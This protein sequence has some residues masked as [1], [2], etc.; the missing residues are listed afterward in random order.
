MGIV[1][2]ARDVA[3]DRPVAIKLLP[4]ALAG[5]RRL[6]ERFVR[7]ARLAARLSHPNI[8]PIHAV[9]E[10]GRLVW[11]VMAF[12]PGES[13]GQRLRA[14]GPL[15][16]A[17]VARILRDIAW[18]LAYAHGQGVI[19]RDVKPD[20][21]LLE[22]GGRRALIA[23][24][25]IARPVQDLDADQEPVAGTI[26]YLSPEQARGERLDGRSDLYSLGVVGY[27][28]LAARLPYP[29]ATLAELVE[30]QLAG[31]P[32]ALATVGP[33]L[34]RA[35][36]RAIDRCL[37]LRPDARPRNG[38]ELA[39]VLERLDSMPTDLPAPLRVWLTKGNQ[40]RGALFLWTLTFGLPA[41]FTAFALLANGIHAGGAALLG[42]GLVVAAPWA[43]YFGSRLTQTRKVLAAG[44]T[45]S[46]LVLAIRNQAER[47]RE[48]IAFEIGKPPT[49]L[50]RVLRRMTWGL[51]GGAVASAFVL[52]WIGLTP[53]MFK[54]AWLTLSGLAVGGAILGMLIPGRDLPARDRRSEW[55][56]KF[57]AGPFGRGL[58]RL[59]GW[60]LKRR[61]SPEQSLHRPTELALGDAA[62][63]LFQALPETER[64][65]LQ[66]LP[67]QIRYLSGQAQA[68][69]RKIEELDDL[70]A[71]AAPETLFGEGRGR[72]SDGGAAELTEARE[73][74]AAR[75]RETI[76][77]LEALRLGLLRLHAGNAV[78]ESLTADLEAAEELKQRLEHLADGQ[79]AVQLVLKGE[80]PH[81]PS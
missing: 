42:L 21:V 12:V 78:P 31:P 19:H 68:M 66:Q 36:C 67:Q 10:A 57:W 80:V 7:E 41:G 32:P 14:R 75:L 27:T 1:F 28:A 29:A 79:A 65:D 44:Y 20:N 46:D 61:E 71:R 8:V 18:G 54:Y 4:P 60:R 55:R 81:H 34:P 30:R 37:S 2:L 25:G 70:I 33:H 26:G 74:W 52:P 24:F 63:A 76:S 45:A 39:D 62:E 11:F 73:L 13:L 59:A 3:L 53:T 69:R 72:T 22:T 38:E 49:R 51:F 15:P 48:E 23:D 47:R 9:E 56:E 43:L 64:R 16:P 6:R 58:I 77:L 17:E 35:L 40:L 50:G 5:N